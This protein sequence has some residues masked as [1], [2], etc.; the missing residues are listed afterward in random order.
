M[1]TDTWRKHSTERMIVNRILSN[2]ASESQ[3][4][5]IY[6]L[7]SPLDDVSAS[8]MIP[9]VLVRVKSLLEPMKRLSRF[10]SNEKKVNESIFILCFAS[11]SV[12]CSRFSHSI[13]L[14]CLFVVFFLLFNI[15][16]SRMT[17]AR[18][19]IVLGTTLSFWIDVFLKPTIEEKK[20]VSS[21]ETHTHT[22]ERKKKM[23]G[24]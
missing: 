21:V 2:R 14:M 7:V 17:L 11:F 16:T 22:G 20:R 23:G 9:S 5:G 4:R 6:T 13:C 1:S 8:K 3:C 12:P 19:A 15:Q 24:E 18:V 10:H